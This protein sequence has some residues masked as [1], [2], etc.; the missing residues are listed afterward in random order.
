MVVFYLLR[1][2][3][4]GSLGS[5]LRVLLAQLQLD[6]FHAFHPSK[7]GHGEGIP[8]ARLRCYSDDNVSAFVDERTSPCY[9]TSAAR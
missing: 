3:R 4:V 8:H 9:R 1:P 6:S 2:R 7:R 5:R